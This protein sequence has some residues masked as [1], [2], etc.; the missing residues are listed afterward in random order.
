MRQTK[1]DLVHVAHKVE[2]EGI[3]IFMNV[4]LS[5]IIK[6]FQDSRIFRCIESIDNDCEIII[7]YA[8]NSSLYSKIIERYPSIKIVR[9]PVGNLSISCNLGINQSTGNAVLIMDSDSVF[10][11]GS[12]DLITQQLNQSLVVKPRIIYQYTRHIVGSRIVAMARQRFNDTNIR[13]L[14][15]GLAFR[16]EIVNLIDGC[17]FDDRIPFTEDAVLDWRLKRAGVGLKFLPKAVVY[18]SPISLFHDLRAAYRMG[19]GHRTAVHFAGRENDNGGKSII[20]RILTGKSI[21]SCLSEGKN[22]GV[23][24][25]LHSAAWGALYNVGYLVET[26]RIRLVERQST[27][28]DDWAVKLACEHGRKWWRN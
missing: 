13:A 18:H 12:L 7:S 17:L 19:Y 3:Q 20:S 2:S 22:Y 8:G 16:K 21:M 25:A 9:S 11:P 23:G 14:T 26:F 24:V 4:H 28:H 27:W 1:C 6:C 10:K 15:P 5:I